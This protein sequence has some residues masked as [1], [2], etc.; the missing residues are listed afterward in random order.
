MAAISCI[1]VIAMYII[2]TAPYG[3]RRHGR[4][5]IALLTILGIDVVSRGLAMAGATLFRARIMACSMFLAVVAASSEI[6][7]YVAV[8]M[9]AFGGRNV[10]IRTTDSA[11]FV[12]AFNAGTTLDFNYNGSS[13][14][15]AAACSL[16]ASSDGYTAAIRSHNESP[17]FLTSAISTKHLTCA[18]RI[19][20]ANVCILIP[21]SVF[22][23]A[24]KTRNYDK[25]ILCVLEAS[26]A[27]KVGQRTFKRVHS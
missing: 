22:I 26:S 14:R 20:S 24:L 13:T 18:V 2:R 12:V 17:V 8:F 10:F 3:F 4:G 27:A 15:K 7:A 21:T 11:H 23:T 1:S 6:L 16:L 19:I 25:A 5:R 9:H